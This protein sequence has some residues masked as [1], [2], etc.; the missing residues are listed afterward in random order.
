MDNPPKR[1]REN[2][3]LT[4]DFN[5]EATYH[6]LCHDGPR[7]IDKV[8]AFI[9]S[10]G[11][12]LKHKCDGPSERLTRHSHYVRLSLNGLTIWRI[13]CP[14][15]LAVFTVLPPDDDTNRP[16][17]QCDGPEVVYDEGVSSR[18]WKPTGLPQWLCHFGE[19][20]SL[21]AAGDKRGEV[22]H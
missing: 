3:T 14:K 10:L 9:L 2:R 1:S 5:N 7:F 21:S 8:V 13:Q 17:P 11:L 15:C 4:V 16:D 18:R 22:C 20:D 12:Q 19:L 6:R